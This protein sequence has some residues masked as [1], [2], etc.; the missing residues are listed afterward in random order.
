MKQ[1]KQA[2]LPV[3]ELYRYIYALP[4]H[5]LHLYEKTHTTNIVINNSTISK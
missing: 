2:K 1:L 5:L 4:I 3:S